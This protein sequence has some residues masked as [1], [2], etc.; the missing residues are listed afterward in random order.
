L[1]TI[2]EAKLEDGGLWVLVK[3]LALGGLSLRT[4]RRRSGFG[5]AIHLDH[6]AAQQGGDDGGD[7]TRGTELGSFW[8]LLTKKPHWD[9]K[10]KPTDRKR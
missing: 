3:E 8:G 1:A 6:A 5:L 9:P 10:R 4:E 7:G 2:V